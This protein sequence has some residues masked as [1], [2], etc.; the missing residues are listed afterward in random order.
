MDDYK[1]GNSALVSGGGTFRLY[2]GEALDV[3]MLL[4]LLLLPLSPPLGLVE[5]YGQIAAKGWNHDSKAGGVVGGSVCGNM[6]LPPPLPN[7]LTV[8]GPTPP[9]TLLL[10]I[11]CFACSVMLPV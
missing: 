2:V 10:A 8:R 6:T 5:D 9:L 4:L 11:L 7:P 3:V 1:K